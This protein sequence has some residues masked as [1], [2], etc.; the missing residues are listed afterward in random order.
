ML[1][2]KGVVLDY[3]KKSVS[4]VFFLVLFVLISAFLD[5]P[6]V[7]AGE[8]LNFAGDL[9]LDCSFQLEK[10]LSF[11]NINFKISALIDDSGVHLTG[12]YMVW[13]NSPGRLTVGKKYLRL[14]PGYFSQ[15]VLSEEG[16]S[17]NHVALESKHT[18]FGMD[19]EAFQLIAFLGDG[20]KRKLF[21]HRLSTDSLLPGLEFGAS[22]AMMVS[23]KEHPLYYLPLPFWPYYLSKKIIGIN[24]VYDNYSDH[25]IGI[26]FTYT[27]SNRARVYGELLVDEYPYRSWHRNPDKRAHLLG[28]Y[29]PLGRDLELRVEYSNVFNYMYVHRFPQNN[30]LYQGEPIG[31]WLGPDGD[32]LDMEFEKSAGKDRTLKLGLQYVRK[33]PGSFS[34]DYD[35][36]EDYYAT[37]FLSSIVE[38]R[39]FFRLEYEAKLNRMLSAELG[40]KAGRIW[41]EVENTHKDVLLLGLGVNLS[42]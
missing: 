10:E 37:R 31:H 12:L 22:E 42:L 4:V 6:P 27:F 25:Y 28:I 24:S 38:R 11:K 39:A 8:D 40:L 26:D 21:V 34:E 33:G 17:L 2:I 23:E 41:D 30:Y 29:Y 20:V 1:N 19:F 13:P 15:L 5:G 16:P 3:L 36:A 9:Q 14:G 35:T 7:F 32:V 18:W